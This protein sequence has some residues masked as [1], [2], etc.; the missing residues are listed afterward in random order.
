M[1]KVKKNANGSIAHYKARLVVKGYKQYI[2]IDY[3]ETFVPVAKF[4]TIRLLLAIAAINDIKIDQ[5][6]IVTTFLNGILLNKEAVYMI[7][8]EGCRLPPRTIVKLLQ[9]LYRLK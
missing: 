9:M 3:D 7:A 4:D 5:I 2:H 8:P 1:F 6:D